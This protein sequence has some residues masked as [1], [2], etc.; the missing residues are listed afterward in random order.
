MKGALTDPAAGVGLGYMRLALPS[1]RTPRVVVIGSHALTIQSHLPDGGFKGV[2][3][4][5]V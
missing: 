3:G 4:G 1:T 2:S 5:L